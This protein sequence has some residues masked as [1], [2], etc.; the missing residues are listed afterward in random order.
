MTSG[1]KKFLRVVIITLMAVGFSN[2][3]EA[4]GFPVATF[5]GMQTT[6]SFRTIADEIQKIKLQIEENIKAAMETVLEGYG[7]AAND[8]FSPLKSFK[9]EFDRF[10]NDLTSL[11]SSA[12]SSLQD[13][14]N[15]VTQQAKE[16]ANRANAMGNELASS[17]TQQKAYLQQA[18]EL[19]YAAEREAAKAQNTLENSESGFNRA[20]NWLKENR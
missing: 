18:K 7:M 9:G 17:I 6:Y 16:A 12:L 1:F 11:K 10:G 20:Y 2:K 19:R 5:D 14:R 15:T 13:A 3:A 4:F 8:L